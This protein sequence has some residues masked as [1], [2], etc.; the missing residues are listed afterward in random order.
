MKL[1]HQKF[2]LLA[3]FATA[4][5]EDIGGYLRHCRR[6][7]IFLQFRMVMSDSLQSRG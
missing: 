2:N 6:S 1:G 4:T 5:V 3:L 7:M